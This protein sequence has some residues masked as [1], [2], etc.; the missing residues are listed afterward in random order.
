MKLIRTLLS[1]AGISLLATSCASFS[2][3]QLPKVANKPATSVKKVPITY[4]LK[5]GSNLA[6]GQ[7]EFAEP[8]RAKIEKTMVD[9]FHKS[10]RFS[11]VSQGKGGGVHVDVD[12]RNHGNAAAATI[13]GF[14][15]GATFLTIP[16][17]ATDHY[18]LTATAR[19]ASGKA[20][21]Y[22]LNESVTTVF[23]LPLIVAT[24]F[25][26]PGSVFPKV[27]ENMYRNLIVNMERDGI[28]PKA[29]N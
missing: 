7:T 25:A 1:F 2:G 17:F 13:S 23:W 12:V 3:N 11:S 27:H 24:P 26:H 19:T 18:K 5:A 28:L 21:Q 4:T 16:G 29:S 8:D 14:I 22:E 9:A 15:S 10:E 20:R 6:G